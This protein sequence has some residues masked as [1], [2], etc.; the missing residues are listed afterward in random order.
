MN[1]KNRIGGTSDSSNRSEKALRTGHFRSHRS[2]DRAS[3]AKNHSPRAL[4]SVDSALAY[5]GDD[6]LG[7]G[8]GIIIKF[9]DR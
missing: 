9:K 5:K 7:D 6:E 3:H 8:G 1:F 2:T 4:L